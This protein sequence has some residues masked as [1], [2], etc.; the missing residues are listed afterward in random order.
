MNTCSAIIKVTANL[1]RTEEKKIQKCPMNKIQCY[2]SVR[3]F[4]MLPPSFDPL[5]FHCQLDYV[6]SMKCI[7]GKQ[8]PEIR[9][10]RKGVRGSDVKSFLRLL[11]RRSL[12][13]MYNPLQR[14][15][16]RS[17]KQNQMDEK[18][19]LIKEAGHIVN[20]L[21]EDVYVE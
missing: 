10:G 9:P 20:E 8:L 15:G 2:Y 19:N 17:Q 12:A 7:V 3:C 1:T 16:I 21:S 5:A 18:I 13:I 4:C 11:F 14:A 6:Q